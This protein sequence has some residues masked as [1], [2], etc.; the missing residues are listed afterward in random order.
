MARTVHVLLVEDDDVDVMAVERAFRDLKLANPLYRARD[1][2]EALAMLRG[3][4]GHTAVPR[5]F[6]VLLDLNM[7]R[8]NGIEFLQ[9]VRKDPD[10]AGSVVFVLTTSKQDEDRLRAYGLGAA[11]YILKDNVGDDFIN[12]VTML[13]HYW[14]VVELP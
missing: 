12:L 14:R 13:E 8:M 5:P 10:H 11:G 6:I 9:A 7:P 2:L 1:G 4:D 3:D